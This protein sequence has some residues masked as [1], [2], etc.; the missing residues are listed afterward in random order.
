MERRTPASPIVQW[1]LWR[2]KNG[3]G[4]T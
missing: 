2:G 3:G 1:Y 4:F